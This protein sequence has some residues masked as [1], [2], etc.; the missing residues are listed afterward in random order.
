M[1][2][3]SETTESAK[4]LV[5]LPEEDFRV[6][7]RTAVGRD[8]AT[9]I[10]DALTGPMVIARTKAVLTDFNRDVEGQLGIAAAAL[11][12]ARAEGREKYLDVKA[13][14]AEWRRKAMTFRRLVQHKLALVKARAISHPKQPPQASPLPAP[15]TSQ[16]LP[17]TIPQPPG[18]KVARQ[19]FREGLEELARAVAAHRD[20]ILS[21]HG[22]EDDD[23]DLWDFLDKITVPAGDGTEQ[24]LTQWLTH[25]DKVREGGR[26]A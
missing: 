24:P 2:V 1:T 10:W 23:D 26:D 15:W 18:S 20:K 8:G 13:A 16:P 25:L 22:E 5:A 11:I 4:A 6:L 9:V 19:R 14:N 7:V 21:G 17:G 3:T 12:E